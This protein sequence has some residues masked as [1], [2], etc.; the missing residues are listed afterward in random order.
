M[1]PT[2]D[3]SKNHERPTPFSYAPRERRH[4]VNKNLQLKLSWDF[5]LGTVINTGVKCDDLFKLET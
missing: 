5:S 2:N 4:L 3:S 1:R